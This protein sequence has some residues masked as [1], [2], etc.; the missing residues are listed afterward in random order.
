MELLSSGSSAAGH[1]TGRDMR[2]QDGWDEHAKF[3]DGL[4]DEGFI[5]L[6]G[7]RWRATARRCTSSKRRPRRRYE[8]DLARTRGG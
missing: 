3:M 5:L 6:G 2:E 1:G 7:H 8:S 4:V